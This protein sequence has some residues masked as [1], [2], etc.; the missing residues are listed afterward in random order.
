VLLPRLAYL[1]AAPHAA[2]TCYL[3]TRPATRFCRTLPAALATAKRSGMGH[4]EAKHAKTAA[5][6]IF[7]APAAA[8]TLAFNLLKHHCRAAWRRRILPARQ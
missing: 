8:I 3:S 2:H 5:G 1:P 6:I 7:A 4:L